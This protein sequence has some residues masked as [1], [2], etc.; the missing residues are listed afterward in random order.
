MRTKE[1]G[2]W[3]WSRN[4]C[5]AE[6]PPAP[7]TPPESS[8]ASARTR[9]STTRSASSVRSVRGTSRSDTL[10]SPPAAGGASP[11]PRPP[12]KP[13][14]RA[15]V[16]I[17]VFTKNPRL[18]GSSS[19]QHLAAEHLQGAVHVAHAGAEQR[20]GQPV[21]APREE[22]PP[23]RVLAGRPGSRRRSGTLRRSAASV[24]RGRSG[25]T[26]SPRR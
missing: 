16:I 23:P 19:R 21:V 3:S 14:C 25:R 15:R 1:R 17:S 22:P 7:E 10:L 9:R 24:G 26:G 18:S 20:P 12:A 2:G 13:S 8:P 11:A 4:C 6:P 5:D